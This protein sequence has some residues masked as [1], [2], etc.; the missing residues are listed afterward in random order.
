MLESTVWSQCDL[1]IHQCIREENIYGKEY[2]SVSIIKKLS[3]QCE[4]V[5]IPNL[6]R[7]PKYIFPQIQHYDGDVRWDGSAYFWRDHYIDENYNSMSLADLR[8]MILDENLICAS[9]IL[10]GQEAFFEVVKLREQDWDFKVSD[11]LKRMMREKQLFYDPAHLTNVTL[12]FIAAKLFERLGMDATILDFDVIQP[13]DSIDL[14]IY[15]AVCNA[16]KL[17]YSVET[18]RRHSCKNL[19]G[20]QMDLEEYIR[21]Y[22]AWNFPNRSML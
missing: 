3:P 22:I 12:S 9:D 6:H 4:I 17:K 10:A 1:F 13:L 21:Q 8:D 2:A 19:S 18:F 15:K 20:S 11:F 5:G 7:L 14:P 16:L